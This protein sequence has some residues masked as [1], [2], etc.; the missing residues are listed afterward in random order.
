LSGA[1]FLPKVVDHPF[2]T[3]STYIAKSVRSIEMDRRKAL[4]TIGLSS[5]AGTLFSRVARA[6]VEEKVADDS[7]EEIVQLLFV[8]ESEGFRSDG[9]SMTLVGVNPRTLWFANRPQKM[10]GF[11]SFDKFVD[12]VATGPDNFEEDPPNATLVILGDDAMT[13]VVMAVP[14]KPTMEDGN[15][16]FPTVDVIEGELPAEGGASAFF[17]DVV[18]RPMSPGSVAGVHRRQVRRTVR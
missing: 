7:G 11:L 13:E 15:L 3:K 14:E 18:G 9:T 5:L 10:A 16:V 6:D 2:N 8:Q 1:A 4:A 12:L 17:I